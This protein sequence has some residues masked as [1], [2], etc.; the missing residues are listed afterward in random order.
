MPGLWAKIDRRQKVTYSFRRLASGFV[1]AA[2]AL[3]LIMS[4]ALSTQSQV[5]SPLSET[6]VEALTADIVPDGVG[7]EQ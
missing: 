5:S 6:Y 4:A 2:A 1:T 3:C 7:L